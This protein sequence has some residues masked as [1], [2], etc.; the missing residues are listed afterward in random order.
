[1][2]SRKTVEEN[3]HPDA[4]LIDLPIWLPSQ[5]IGLKESPAR[6][7]TGLNGC[8]CNVRNVGFCFP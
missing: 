5:G 4:D 7:P 3:L 1:M 8:F 2:R 6:T